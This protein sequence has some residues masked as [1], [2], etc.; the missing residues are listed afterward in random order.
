[1]SDTNEDLRDDGVTNEDFLRMA[2]RCAGPD[3]MVL[4]LGFD[5]DDA[6]QVM[7][8]NLTNGVKLEDTDDEL[9][10]AVYFD[11]GGEKLEYLFAHGELDMHHWGKIV[12]KMN[13]ESELINAG[14]H[15][16]SAKDFYLWINL[17]NFLVQTWGMVAVPPDVREGITMVER[18]FGRT[19]ESMDGI[20]LI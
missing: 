2:L 15:N 19:I 6:E 1:M 7:V 9:P 17:C 10:S 14:I 18:L 13:D 5:T 11:A 12:K 3:T 16:P 8:K 20:G 4:G